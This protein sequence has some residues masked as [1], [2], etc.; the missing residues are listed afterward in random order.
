MSGP[1]VLFSLRD[2]RWPGIEFR[3]DDFALAAILR[4]PDAVVT[5]PLES[6]SGGIEVSLQL[7]QPGR[8]A[9]DGTLRMGS[10]AKSAFFL[11]GGLANGLG[12]DVADVW[13]WIRDWLGPDLPCTLFSAAGSGEM[14]KVPF[15]SSV[16]DLLE[17]LAA[18]R[19]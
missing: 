12:D 8:P 4:W 14:L 5:G 13:V 10:D 9:V 11:G 17:I 3:L 16:A 19:G 2:G 7:Q 15:G 18:A 1:V 6:E